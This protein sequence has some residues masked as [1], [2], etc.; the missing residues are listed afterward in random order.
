MCTKATLSSLLLAEA[1]WLAVLAT[2]LGLAAGHGLTGLLGWML[3]DDQSVPLRGAI[4]L[5]EELWVPA[6]ALTVAA[7][8]SALPV[9]AAYRSSAVALLNER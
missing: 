2:V 3:E 1:L 7:L 5:A 8:A 4:W 9:L 6:L